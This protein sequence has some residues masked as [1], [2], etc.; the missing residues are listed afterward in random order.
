M[1]AP[2][3]N[4]RVIAVEFTVTLVTFTEGSLA[5]DN[6]FLKIT[7]NLQKELWIEGHNFTL[8]NIMILKRAYQN[9][10]NAFNC[11]ACSFYVKIISKAW[12]YNFIHIWSIFCIKNIWS[13]KAIRKCWSVCAWVRNSQGFR[14]ATSQQVALFICQTIVIK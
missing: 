13:I 7:I 11:F 9:I 8:E 14:N 12:V 3:S 2:I 6:A 4:Y 1:T 10:L 5:F